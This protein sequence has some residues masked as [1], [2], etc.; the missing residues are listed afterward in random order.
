V[1]KICRRRFVEKKR[2]IKVEVEKGQDNYRPDLRIFLE[3]N[4]E[5]N[6]EVVYKNPLGDKLDV[7]R[8]KESNL[9][10]WFITAQV[11][12]MPAWAQ[13][14][15]LEIREDDSL[16]H[17]KRGEERLLLVTSSPPTNHTCSPYGIAYIAKV[18]C[19]SCHHETKIALLSSWYPMWAKRQGSE[20]YMGIGNY[21]ICYHNNL[22]NNEVPYSFWNQ[23]NSSYGTKLSL[24]Y[25]KTA[26]SKY[27]MN[28]CSQCGAK[29]GDFFLFEA[30]VEKVQANIAV[31]TIEK[32][33]IS[34]TLTD[35]EKGKIE[36]TKP[37]D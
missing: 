2:V 20:S 34:F 15:W 29:I 35:W 17:P 27:L 7:Y 19:Y 37:Q 14:G 24:D 13:H 36:N 23:I 10:V 6:C 5:I 32:V 11:N 26:Q 9:L 1:C 25:S 4:I 16:F 8:H 33:E 18:D 21:D 12:E 3:D 28:H 22:S 30:I 31:S